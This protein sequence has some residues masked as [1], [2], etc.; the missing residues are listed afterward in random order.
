MLSCA[1]RAS[2]PA[3]CLRRRS[4]THTRTRACSCAAQERGRGQRDVWG[5]GTLTSCG[6]VAAGVRGAQQQ[7]AHRGEPCSTDAR[8]S[9]SSAQPPHPGR[10]KAYAWVTAG[11]GCLQL[12]IAPLAAQQGGAFYS[13]GSRKTRS[14]AHTGPAAHRRLL[15]TALL[16]ENVQPDTVT[17]AESAEIAPPCNSQRRACSVGDTS[18]PYI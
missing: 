13:L 6:A 4:T 10:T 16:F 14:H 3:P 11:Y 2:A 5:G 18:Q 15:R 12:Q 1:S 17:V 9:A 7:R 8:T